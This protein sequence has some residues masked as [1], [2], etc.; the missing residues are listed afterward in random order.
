MVSGNFPDTEKVVTW[1]AF[2]M[3]F[4]GFDEFQASKLALI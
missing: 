1:A 3:D 4:I 2:F